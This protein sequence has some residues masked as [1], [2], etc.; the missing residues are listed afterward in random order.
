[1]KKG[2]QCLKDRTMGN[3]Q[4]VLSKGAKYTDSHF[5]KMIVMI[6]EEWNKSGETRSRKLAAVFPT[7]T[8][9]WINVVA[10]GTDKNGTIMKTEVIGIGD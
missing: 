2:L 5:I 1:M 3:Q 9:I 4:K 8:M 10:V 6:C 7:R